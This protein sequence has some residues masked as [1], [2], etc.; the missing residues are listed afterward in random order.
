[1][2]EFYVKDLE[3][4]FICACSCL[5]GR[6]SRLFHTIMTRSPD[7]QR[8]TASEDERSSNNN[9]TLIPHTHPC[10]IYPL[11]SQS[12]DIFFYTPLLIISQIVLISSIII[13]DRQHNL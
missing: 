4:D 2:S 8:H 6:E 11:E 10:V 9:L 13:R 3:G 1:M 12:R 7:P 5:R